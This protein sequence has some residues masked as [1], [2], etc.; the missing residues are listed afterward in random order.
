MS[1]APPLERTRDLVTSALVTA[2]LAASAYV[3]VPLQP[4]PVTLQ[5]FF[6]TLSALLLPVRWA[7]SAVV[8]YLLLGAAGLPVFS[9][10]K[11][12]LGVLA[13]PTGGYLIGFLVA[14]ALGSA[15]RAVAVRSGTRLV[16]ADAEAG[17]TVV[18]AIYAVGTTWLA[19][20]A[21][22][23][24]LEAIA[25][26]AAPFVLPDAAKVVAAVG[27]AAAVRRARTR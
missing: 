19:V 24:P 23:T 8:A 27:V 13:G 21:G 26:G 9:G 16:V 15:V 14:A 1:T 2:L 4:V 10:A 25:A 12:G 18:L 6:V 22:L 11:G 17:A 5:V 7:T 20:V 3:V